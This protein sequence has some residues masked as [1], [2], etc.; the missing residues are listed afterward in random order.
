MPDVKRLSFRHSRRKTIMIKGNTRKRTFRAIYRL[1]DRVSPVP[2][3]CGTICG[4][5]CCN[6]V[7]YSEDMGMILLPGEEKL[8]DR[9]SDW[10]KWE[11]FDAEES[12]FPDTWIGKVYFVK[13][14]NPPK[15]PRNLRPM[16]CRTFPLLP[17]ID[18]EGNLHLIYN[19]YELPYVC[20]MIED[21]VELD[22][23]FIRATFTAWKH[24]IC[25]PLIR[26]MIELESAGR[27]EIGNSDYLENSAV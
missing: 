10:L 17:H 26:D 15:C 20:P 25:D 11:A 13:C 3:D 6:A 4:A 23:R 7:D 16:Q 9:Q 24:L 5:V 14:K 19:D 27:D 21:E 22:P 8:H 2:F 12:D 18:K 1:L